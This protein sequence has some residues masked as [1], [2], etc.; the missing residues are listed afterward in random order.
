LELEISGNLT[1][2]PSN[3]GNLEEQSLLFEHSNSFKFSCAGGSQD[4]EIKGYNFQ[5]AC[6]GGSEECG[7][8]GHNVEINVNMA[9]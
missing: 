2:T 7:V 9:T 8:K 4:R 1:L 6:V 3:N 5:Q